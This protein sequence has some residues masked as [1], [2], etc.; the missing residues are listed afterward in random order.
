MID[1]NAASVRCS[2]RYCAMRRC[3][4][5]RR[6]RSNSVL[7]RDVAET[8][9]SG[10]ARPEVI[11]DACARVCCGDGTGAP[12]LSPTEVNIAH[13]PCPAGWRHGPPHRTCGPDSAAPGTGVRTRGG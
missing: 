8:S 7:S 9:V 10:A 6:G 13:P 11:A 4:G 1:R 5:E 12:P 3:P 2:M